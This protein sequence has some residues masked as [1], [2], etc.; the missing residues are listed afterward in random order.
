MQTL[1][2]KH[3]EEETRHTGKQKIHHLTSY[4]RITA[5]KDQMKQYMQLK[6]TVNPI[7]TN[8]A[9]TN[10]RR[11]TGHIQNHTTLSIRQWYTNKTLTQR[12]HPQKPRIPDVLQTQSADKHTIP[13]N[14]YTQ[15]KPHNQT[16]K[17]LNKRPALLGGP[18]HKRHKTTESNKTIPHQ[19]R[20]PGLLGERPT[21]T[22]NV[23]IRTKLAVT[24]KTPTQ[25]TT[26]NHPFPH[27]RVPLMSIKFT[28]PPTT[29]PQSHS[30]NYKR[31]RPHNPTK[32]TI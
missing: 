10:R 21:N 3:H 1:Y 11:Y 20:R 27:K 16:F 26:Q 18:T 25:P 17:A 9:R 23:H 19:T 32:N 24:S 5:T 6:L 14:K 2:G 12:A 31:Q 29:T 30:K 7:A 13:T 8:S 22:A 15:A 28:K 4:L